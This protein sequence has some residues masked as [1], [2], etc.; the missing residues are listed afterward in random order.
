ALFAPCL[1]PG[2]VSVKPQPDSRTPAPEASFLQIVFAVWSS[3]FGV[4]KR[5]DHDAIARSIK[6]QHLIVAGLV[7][8]LLF[9]LTLVVIVRIVIASA[10]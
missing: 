8:A 7:G 10:A 3:F 9:V 1:A 2:P 4:R 6:P 5:R